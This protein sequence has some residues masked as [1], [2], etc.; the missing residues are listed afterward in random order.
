MP[1]DGR[2]GTEIWYTYTLEYYSAIKIDFMKFAGRWMEPENIIL[3]KV[4]QTQKK[5]ML[6]TH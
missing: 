1:L 4:T 6:C 5:Y 3:S 2:I